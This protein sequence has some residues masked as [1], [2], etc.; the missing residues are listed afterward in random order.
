MSSPLSPAAQLFVRTRL[1][2]ILQL[3]IVLLL[4]AD[5]D[6]WWSAERVA[7]QLR[8]AVDAARLAL[9]ALASGNLL[10]VRIASDLTYRFAPW[11]ESAARV[12]GEIAAS[13]YEAR[14]IVARAAAAGTAERFAN[15]FRIRKSDG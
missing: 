8:V 6:V 10:D 5:A 1:G 9:E 14:E 2:S 3:D 7:A 12:L 11:H 15:A 4:Q 13:H